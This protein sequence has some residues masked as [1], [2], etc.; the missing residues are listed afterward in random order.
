MCIRDRSDKLCGIATYHKIDLLLC[1]PVFQQRKNTAAHPIH[2][3]RSVSYTHLDVYKRQVCTRLAFRLAELVLLKV[4]CVVFL[5]MFLEK[6]E[7]VTAPIVPIA[8]L[9]VVLVQDVYKRQN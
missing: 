9:Q 3:M 1:K 8:L 2:W 7:R 4:G 6:I 5:R